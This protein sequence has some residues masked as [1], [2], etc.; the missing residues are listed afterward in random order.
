VEQIPISCTLEHLTLA[1]EGNTSVMII[2]NIWRVWVKEASIT[3]V[4]EES[5][6]LW[7]Y[8]K[9]NKIHV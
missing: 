7:I 9:E 5:K 6:T 4:C 8:Q 1:T 3:N 2:K